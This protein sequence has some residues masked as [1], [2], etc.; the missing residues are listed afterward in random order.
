[1]GVL[2]RR[3]LIPVVH[4]LHAE[5]VIIGLQ[6]AIFF[7]NVQQNEI[8]LQKTDR[9]LAKCF[10]YARHGRHGA[11]RPNANKPFITVRLDLITEIN[12]L[13]QH[14]D[15]E[16]GQIA[17]PAQQDFHDFFFYCKMWRLRC[18]ASLR[19]ATNN[20]YSIAI[21]RSSL[22]SVNILPVPSTTDA[23]GS[24]AIDTGSPVSSRIRRSRFLIKAPP[25]VKTMPR[26]LISALSSGGVRSS[27][28]R[29]AFKMVATQSESA[30]RISVSSMLTVLG[31]PSTRLR[32]L[33][34]MVIGLSSG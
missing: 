22:K 28:T 5:A 23:N 19:R 34:S 8:I 26:S 27:A 17:K 6:F 20:C 1:M 30:S 21:R 9:V 12:Q 13:R 32:P 31:T 33:I 4:V 18:Q 14:D 15:D 10:N 3:E 25:P 7:S 11:D 2:C 24:S 16:D 29:I